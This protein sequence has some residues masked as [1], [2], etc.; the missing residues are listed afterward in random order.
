VRDALISISYWKNDP[1]IVGSVPRGAALRS[2]TGCPFWTM[3]RNT[4]SPVNRM[5]RG[6]GE[7]GI[8]DPSARTISWR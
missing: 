4:L 3:S 6:T 8:A 7:F 2:V 5:V 1:G